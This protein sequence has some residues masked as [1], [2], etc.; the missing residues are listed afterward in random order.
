MMKIKGI[1][2]VSFNKKH[3]KTKPDDISFHD[4]YDEWIYKIK[5]NLKPNTVMKYEGI[6][7]NHLTEFNNCNINDINNYSII[8]FTNSLQSNG[9]SNRTI[10]DILL[11]LNMIFKYAS[12]KFDFHA[13][14]I[15]YLHE[16]KKEMRVL[17]ICEQK[18]LE[19]YL[20]KDMDIHKFGVILALHT[21]MRI[22]EL[23]ALKWEDISD[24][25]INVNKTM[26]RIKNEYG[27]T[28]VIT[29]PP[30]SDSSVRVIPIPH[31]L[32]SYISKFRRNGYVL[33]SKRVEFTEPR[34]M[35][36]KFERYI[37]ECGIENA[38]FH[39][40]RHTFATRCIEAGVDAKTVSEL[41]GHSDAKI[42]L[43]CYIHSSFE[44]KQE[45]IRRMEKLL[46]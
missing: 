12:E 17:N 32:K 25:S 39:C 34:L 20:K 37:K 36:Y 45:S 29:A 4:A 23:C 21:G 8:N 13:P 19:K 9:L 30:K 6:Y 44:H 22:G 16:P 1:Y 41:L 24:F 46:A 14:K 43:K 26:M 27:K 15:E 28:E 40:L 2:Q 42:T 5:S 33:S 11:V 18:K 10:N 38:S 3:I 31:E 35:Q 7:K